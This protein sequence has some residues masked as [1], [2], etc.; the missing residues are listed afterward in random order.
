MKNWTE[1]TDDERKAHESAIL[2][3]ATHC[4]ECKHRLSDCGLKDRSLL[5]WN[6]GCPFYGT[7]LELGETK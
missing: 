3:G 5:C 2:L 7:A 1:L 4:P 6:K